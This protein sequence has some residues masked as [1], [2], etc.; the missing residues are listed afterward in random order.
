MQ[1][2]WETFGDFL[3]FATKMEE[4]FRNKFLFFPNS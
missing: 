4:V 3:T 1:L 2:A